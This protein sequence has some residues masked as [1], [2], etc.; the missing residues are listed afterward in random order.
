MYD[1]ELDTMAKRA[2][3]RIAKKGGSSKV[4][5]QVTR[6]EARRTTVTN[7]RDVT[8][9]LRK[10]RAKLTQHSATARTTRANKKKTLVTLRGKVAS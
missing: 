7:K 6:E 4:F 3:D 1:F 10:L 8:E 2:A 9:I 5:L